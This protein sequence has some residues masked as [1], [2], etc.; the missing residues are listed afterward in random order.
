M[1]EYA[2]YKYRELFCASTHVSALGVSSIIEYIPQMGFQLR[3][4]EERYQLAGSGQES[5]RRRSVAM[6]TT[7]ICPLIEE[8]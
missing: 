5:D 4:E 6:Q 3:T 7:H 2:I 1:R 8:P